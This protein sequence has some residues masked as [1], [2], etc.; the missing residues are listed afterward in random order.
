MW[1]IQGHVLKAQLRVDKVSK[2][3]VVRVAANVPLPEK[4]WYSV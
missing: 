3:V 2:G 1:R 4:G